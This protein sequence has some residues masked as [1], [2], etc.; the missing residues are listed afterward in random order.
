MSGLD[1]IALGG[2]PEARAT[3]VTG[4]SGTGKTVFAVQFLAGGITG[5]AGSSSRNGVFVTCEEPPAEIRRNAAG[6]GFELSEW[7]DRGCFTFVDASPEPGQPDDETGAYDLEGFLARLEHAIER[8]RARRVSIDSVGSLMTR[9]RDSETLRGELHRILSY[10]KSLGVTVVVT[11]E[12]STEDGPIA[13][14]GVE[15]FVADNVIVLR[16][17]LR[18]GSRRR[19]VEVLKFRG[20]EHMKGEWPFAIFPGRGFQVVPHHARSPATGVSRERVTIGQS[21]LDA[22]MGGGVFRGSTTLVSGPPGTGKTLL[23]THFSAGGMNA[24]EGCLLV[25]F[26]E[27]REQLVRNAAGW[28]IDLPFLESRNLL[29]VHCDHPDT[30]GPEEQLIRIENII[31]D[32]QPR[33]IVIDGLSAIA[34]SAGEQGSY[35]FVMG[36]NALVRQHGLVGLLT[37]STSSLL[38][39]E[40]ITECRAS[41]LAD[42]IVLLRY[43]EVSGAVTRGITVLKMRGS[44]H[45]QSLRELQVDDSG[46]RIG[47]VFSNVTGVLAGRLSVITDD[48]LARTHGVLEALPDADTP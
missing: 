43:A 46:M 42:A 13:R 12:R 4:T 33:R 34:N 14:Y 48:E 29:R 18:Q 1:G 26:E 40:S 24:E 2:L 19:T 35:D 37:A 15:E 7:E 38:G 20:A 25:A 30:S 39:G 11:A 22:M 21:E 27:G 45:D 47:R 41:T 8:V 28:G 32:F 44:N 10:L 5:E 23:A 3:L 6:L 17:N 36:F 16:N 31:A 9:F